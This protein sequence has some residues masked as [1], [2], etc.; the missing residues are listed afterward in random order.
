MIKVLKQY[1]QKSKVFLFPLICPKNVNDILEIQCY[2]S[3]KDVY[4][5]D[6]YQLTVVVD[7]SKY[8]E[9]HRDLEGKYLFTS[10]HFKQSEMR[11]LGE[12]KYLYVFDLTD[13]KEVWS[14]VLTGKYSQIPEGIKKVILGYYKGQPTYE[15]VNSWLYPDK[16]YKDYADDLKVDIAI[17]GPE[18]CNLPDLEKEI[19]TS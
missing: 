6:D 15:Y 14:L 12:S 11:R 19:Y 9:I 7:G 2:L 3:R 10:P 4:N 1:V 8:P 18:L 5:I 17:V 16:Y 13:M